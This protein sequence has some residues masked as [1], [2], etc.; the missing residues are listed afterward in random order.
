MH[1]CVYL[2]QEIYQAE[3]EGQKTTNIKDFFFPKILYS[4]QKQDP[5]N[6]WHHLLH[7]PDKHQLTQASG[8]SSN[9]EKEDWKPTVS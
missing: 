3:I 5:Q 2:E 4:V 7:P 9:R 8:I 6:I 1:I